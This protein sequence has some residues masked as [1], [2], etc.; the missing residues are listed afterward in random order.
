M[1]T[2]PEPPEPLTL[3]TSKSFSLSQIRLRSIT[4]LRQQDM[5]TTP[6]SLESISRVHRNIYQ[7]APTHLAILN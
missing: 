1:R 5:L 6:S 3:K 7:V 2:D 4:E